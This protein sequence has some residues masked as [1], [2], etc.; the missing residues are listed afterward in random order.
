MP[1]RG[2]FFNNEQGAIHL[3]TGG[4]LSR[5]SISYN[6]QDTIIQFVLCHLW[7]EFNTKTTPEN[8]NNNNFTLYLNLIY[9]FA[10]NRMVIIRRHTNS[11]KII[12]N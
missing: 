11:S 6:A 10:T 4:C 1:T 3:R 12:A 2:E 8:F 5:Y 9:A 7:I